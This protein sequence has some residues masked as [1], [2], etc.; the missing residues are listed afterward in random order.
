MEGLGTCSNLRRSWA[1]QER[2]ENVVESATRPK[3]PQKEMKPG[4]KSTGSRESFC[5]L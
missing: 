3:G 4:A 1:V 5:L 2:E